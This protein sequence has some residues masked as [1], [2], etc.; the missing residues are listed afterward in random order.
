MVQWD[1]ATA[2]SSFDDFA[3]LDMVGPKVQNGYA[4]NKNKN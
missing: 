1:F 4:G 3:H 2:P